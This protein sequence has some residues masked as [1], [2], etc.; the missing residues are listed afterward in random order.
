MRILFHCFVFARL[1]LAVLNNNLYKHTPKPKQK[2]KEKKS[3]KNQTKQ[4]KNF[5][6]GGIQIIYIETYQTERNVHFGK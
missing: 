5:F 4:K 2:L 3:Q 1:C 6:L